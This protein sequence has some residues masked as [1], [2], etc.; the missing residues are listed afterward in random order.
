MPLAYT[1]ERLQTTQRIDAWS[2][3]CHTWAVVI[4][5]FMSKLRT[6]SIPGFGPQKK[7]FTLDSLSTTGVTSERPS[8]FQKSTPFRA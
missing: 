3:L 2:A 6:H 8:N 1:E 5:F 7:A 4:G